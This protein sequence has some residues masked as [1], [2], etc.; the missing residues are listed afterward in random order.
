MSAT[1]PTLA[2]LVADFESLAVGNECEIA[3]LG[4]GTLFSACSVLANELSGPAFVVFDYLITFGQE[5]NL[6]WKRRFTGATLLFFVN[7]YVVLL[8]YTMNISGSASLSASEK[9]YGLYVNHH[10][11][12]LKMYTLPLAARSFS[13]L[14]AFALSRSWLLGTFVFLLSVV[15]FAVNLVPYH[16]GSQAAIVPPFGCIAIDSISPQ[17]GRNDYR[18]ENM[19]DSLR[20]FMIAITWHS[21]GRGRRMATTTR[22]GLSLA[23]VLLRDGTIYFAVLFVLNCVHLIFTML[24]LELV[25]QN[26]S[27][28][29]IF[30]NPLTAVI[31]SRFLLNLQAANQQALALDSDHDP[32]IASAAYDATH[33]LVFERVVGSL[34]EESVSLWEASPADPEHAPDDKNICLTPIPTGG[35]ESGA[36]LK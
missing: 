34:A 1:E 6:F 26:G 15:P 4:A 14:R 8:L 7:R 23:H 30:T 28:L 20:Y 29:T 9:G 2:A 18:I 36:D 35:P 13:G 31:V 22:N 21:L 5:V 19:L 10:R 12:I 32:Q 24:S 3:A 33:T 11:R 25:F 16:Y 27:Y 17:M